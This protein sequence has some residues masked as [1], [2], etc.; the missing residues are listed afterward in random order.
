MP[1]YIF[2][3]EKLDV[4]QLTVDLADYVL[5]LLDDFPP[6]QHI[7]LVGQMEAAVAS[8]AQNIAGSAP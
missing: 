2:P 3:F 4:W 5:E 8:P 6:N 1:E 7:R